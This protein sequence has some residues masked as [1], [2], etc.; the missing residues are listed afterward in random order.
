[1]KK[2]ATLGKVF[3]T[4]ISRFQLSGTN[5]LKQNSDNQISLMSLQNYAC[6]IF[7]TS[8]ISFI[9]ALT[10]FVFAWTIIRLLSN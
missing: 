6:R 5:V 10:I 2:I 1:M 9:S 7:I 4:E 3:R 8:W